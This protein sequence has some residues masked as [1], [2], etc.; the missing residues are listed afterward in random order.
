MSST[1]VLYFEAQSLEPRISSC[2]T[3]ANTVHFTLLHLF[4]N[5]CWF[6]VFLMSFY[7]F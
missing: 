5:L 1:S 7:F 3:K 6:Y 4:D 2:T